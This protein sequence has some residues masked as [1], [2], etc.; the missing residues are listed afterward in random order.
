MI[1]QNNNLLFAIAGTLFLL[2]F[3]LL[4][5]VIDSRK[6]WNKL[7]GNRRGATSDDITK[8]TLIRLGKVEAM[9][10]ALR[11]QVAF[12]NEATRTSIQKVGFKRYNPF[13]DTG[14]DQSFSLA[15][16]DHE[17]NGIVL[18]SLYLREGVRVYAKRIEDGKAQQTLFDEEKEVLEQILNGIATPLT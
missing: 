11:P 12:F 1:L 14:S 4:W 9:L 5:L 2:S 10:E 8:D 17:N 18:S 6:K 3:V 15:L 7:F 16:L 13:K